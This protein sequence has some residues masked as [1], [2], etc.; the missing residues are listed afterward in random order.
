[1]EMIE[2]LLLIFEFLHVKPGKGAAFVRTKI[3]NYVTGTTVEKTFRAGISMSETDVAKETK[4]YT[5][6]EGAQFVFMDLT[7]YGEIRLNDSDVGDKKK[8]LNEEVAE[9]RNGLH[10]ALLE[11]KGWS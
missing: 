9:R 4:Q 11:G 8:W 7:T 2:V 10:Y 3:R 1:M 6:K 5:Y